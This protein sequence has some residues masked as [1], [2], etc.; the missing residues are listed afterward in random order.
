VWRTLEQWFRTDDGE[1]QPKHVPKRRVKQDGRYRYVG[2]C[3]GGLQGPSVN[4][5]GVFQAGHWVVPSVAISPLYAIHCCLSETGFVLCVCPCAEAETADEDAAA[6]QHV[7]AC[8]IDPAQPTKLP[9]DGTIKLMQLKGYDLS[10]VAWPEHHM[11]RPRISLACPLLPF[12][13]PFPFGLPPHLFSVCFMVSRRT[14]SA[15]AW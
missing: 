9:L 12:P 5:H 15:T 4:V 10:K 8:M 3:L 7:W 13:I 14:V 11:R 1:A 6:A 2:E